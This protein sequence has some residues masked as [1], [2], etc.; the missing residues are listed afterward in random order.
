[1]FTLVVFMSSSL[2]DVFMGTGLEIFFF[3]LRPC[4]TNFI[5]RE[6]VFSVYSRFVPVL[7]IF[8]IR[9]FTPNFIS[10]EMGFKNFL[11]LRPYTANFIMGESVFSVYTWW[12]P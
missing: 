5:P 6:T 12:F 3:W 1:V 11:W 8:W 9:P 4:T 10:G 2:R 7:E